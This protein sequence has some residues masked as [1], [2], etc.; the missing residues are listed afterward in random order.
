MQLDLQ[1]KDDTATIQKVCLLRCSGPDG[2]F[3]FLVAS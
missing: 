1:F 2:R 3:P